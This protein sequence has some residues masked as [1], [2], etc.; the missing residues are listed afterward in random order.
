M[1]GPDDYAR[2]G[3][4][5]LT[6]L[7]SLL[8]DVDEFLRSPGI[9][10]A[11]TDFYRDRRGSAFPGQDASLLID[12]VG[13]TLSPWSCVPRPHPRTLQAPDTPLIP[14]GPAAAAAGPASN[15]HAHAHAFLFISPQIR[16]EKKSMTDTGRYRHEQQSPRR[17]P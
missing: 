1:N 10:A 17:P 14:A 16:N 12:S 15:P 8:T 2:A 7:I 13:F 11:L 4:D 3:E 6:G 5:S 9:R